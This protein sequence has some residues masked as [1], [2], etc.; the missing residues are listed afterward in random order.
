MA[1][2][3]L[4]DPSIHGYYYFY[5]VQGTLNAKIQ[6][7]TTQIALDWKRIMVSMYRWVNQLIWG[8]FS[9]S[10]SIL[11][12]P[13]FQICDISEIL[14]SDHEIRRLK[15]WWWIAKMTQYELIDPT[16]H[17]TI[18]FVESRILWIPKSWILHSECHVLMSSGIFW[19]LITSSDVFYVLW[20]V[21]TFSDISWRLVITSDYFW[22]FMTSSDDFWWLLT[23]SDDFWR[24]LTPSDVF[25]RFLTFSDV[26]W[27]ILTSSTSHDIFWRL[28][29][30]FMTSDI[31]WRLLM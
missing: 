2:Y 1:Q 6:D 21:L 24:L 23:S 14:I 28:R 12:Y 3:E 5:S 9:N 16:I 25:W 31:F 19:R 4:I 7:F 22:Q 29:R 15:N 30:I 27:R 8:H 10:L 17:G 20:R 11:N 26:F 18:I 13:D